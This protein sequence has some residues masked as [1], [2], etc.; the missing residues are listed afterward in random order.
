MPALVE[1]ARGSGRCR[2]EGSARF[3]YQ[4]NMAVPLGSEPDD[5]YL[6]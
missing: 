6:N 5:K 4:M 3:G 1:Q 2:L